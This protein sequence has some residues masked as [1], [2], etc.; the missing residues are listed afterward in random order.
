MRGGH[1]AGLKGRCPAGKLPGGGG[2]S[3]EVAVPACIAAGKQKGALQKGKGYKHGGDAGC[4]KQ[5]QYLR[6]NLLGARELRRQRQRCATR[7][8]RLGWA[9]GSPQARGKGSDTCLQGSMRHPAGPLPLPAINSVD[10]APTLPRPASH[11]ADYQE[12]CTRGA[13]YTAAARWRAALSARHQAGQQ[14]QWVAD[15]VGA[16]VQQLQGE[17]GGRAGV[18]PGSGQEG[19]AG[20]RASPT[21]VRGAAKQSSPRQ[22]WRH[23]RCAI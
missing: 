18:A 14:Q 6:L 12:G 1:A 16:E 9:G 7:G 20:R 3:Q 22:S 11:G 19:R 21:S 2:V 13:T 8:V 15:A 5:Q 17:G 4:R 23:I 10:S